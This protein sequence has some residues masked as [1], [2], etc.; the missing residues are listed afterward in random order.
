[1]DEDQFQVTLVSNAK[2][3]DGGEN[4]PEQFA[5]KIPIKRKLDGDWE[6]ALMEIQYPSGSKTIVEDIDLGIVVVAAPDIK[7]LRQE[8]K[9]DF[10]KHVYNRFISLYGLQADETAPELLTLSEE[11]KSPLKVR[12][13]N[14]KT[15]LQKSIGYARARIPSGPCESITHF[16]EILNLTLDAAYT[17]MSSANVVSK[18]LR[19]NY[20]SFLGR[21][22]T[23]IPNCPVLIF[24]KDYNL[25]S[26]LGLPNTKKEE[27]LQLIDTQTVI[28]GES[29]PV[30]DHSPLMF[31]YSN[32][33]DY[34]I[35]GDT[36][37]PL[38]GVVPVKSG[39]RQQSHW[40]FAPPYYIP[41]K[42]SDLNIIGIQLKTDTGDA[43]PIASNGKV[44]LRLHFRRRRHLL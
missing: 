31:I 27:D 26:I 1:M 44:V 9:D 20:N 3:V 2:G 41:V 14:H 25:N 30:L 36:L 16:V 37:T 34:Q 11:E 24:T 19:F 28:K 13:F 8:E 10:D 38:L 17:T 29:A 33:I 12:E 39:A 6:V 43:Y 15:H 23:T 5:N 7:L 18:K 42:T 35:V 4:R 22:S 40:T 21:V 32:I